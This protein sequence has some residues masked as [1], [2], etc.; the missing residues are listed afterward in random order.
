MYV[1]IY[2]YVQVYIHIYTHTSRSLVLELVRE[3]FE[4]RWF[5]L[6]GNA[7][8]GWGNQTVTAHGFGPSKGELS[9]FS[10]CNGRCGI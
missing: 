4:V 10:S 5:G 6:K 1:R 9:S 7:S 3:L 2:I 8:K